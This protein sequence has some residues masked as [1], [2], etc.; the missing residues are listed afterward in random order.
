LTPVD[1]SYAPV[2]TL[3]QIRRNGRGVAAADYDNDGRVD[4]AVNTIGG[5]LLL[6]H[7]TSQAGNWLTVDVRPFSPGAVVTAVDSDGVRQVRDV[8]AGSSYL[9]SEDPRVHFGF[10]TGRPAQLIVRWPD[11]TVKHFTPPANAIFVA[12]R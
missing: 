12:S 5:K 6:L 11:G 7:N 8:Q 4:V 2:A 1:D 3:Q 10:G 9:S